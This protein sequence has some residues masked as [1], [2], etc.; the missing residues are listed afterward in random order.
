MQWMASQDIIRQLLRSNLHQRQ[1]MEQVRD[2]LAILTQQQM[3]QEEHLQLLW[4]VTEKVRAAAAP[5]LAWPGLAWPGLPACLQA[6]LL[7]AHS[8]LNNLQHPHPPPPHPPAGGRVRGRQGQRAPDP[9][10]HL[11]QLLQHPDG[12]AVQQVPGREEPLCARHPAAA[13]ALQ[14]PGGV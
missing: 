9:G 11:G 14:A 7:P 8:A 5:G 2:I 10:R 13:G 1:Y 12:H 4:D 3:L 6:A